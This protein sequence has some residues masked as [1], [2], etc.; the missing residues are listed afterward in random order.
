MNI[1]SLVVVIGIVAAVIMGNANLAEARGFGIRGG[2]SVR[3][4]IGVRRN[5]AV[6]YYGPGFY[7]APRTNGANRQGTTQYQQR[8]WYYSRSG[9]VEYYRPYNPLYRTR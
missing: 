6:R 1:K 7:A 3:L 5:R 8:P 4:G 9:P 2:A